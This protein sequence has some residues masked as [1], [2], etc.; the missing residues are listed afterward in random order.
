MSDIRIRDEHSVG[1]IPG[2]F[3]NG[4]RIAHVR[5]RG[6]TFVVLSYPLEP[7][8]N[9]VPLAKLTAAERQ[10]VDRVIEGR[11]RGDIARG[12]GSS[13]RTV[14]KLLERAYRKLGVRSRGELAARLPLVDTV[15]GLRGLR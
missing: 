9:R 8:R 2:R 3:P 13:A 7:K 10:V 5:T 4:L 15:E 1:T 14:S 12:R 11:T 6:E